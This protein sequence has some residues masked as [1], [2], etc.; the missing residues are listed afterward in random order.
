MEELEKIEIVVL[1]MHQWCNVAGTE[2]RVAVFNDGFQV[3]RG[4]LAA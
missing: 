2:C 4:D 1:Q 3:V